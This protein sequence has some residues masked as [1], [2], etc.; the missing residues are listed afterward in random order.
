MYGSWDMMHDRRMDG[1]MDGKS[2]IYR[3]VPHLITSEYYL[4]VFWLIYVH[5]ILRMWKPLRVHV[6]CT[7][8]TVR[9]I[10]RALFQTSLSHVISNSLWVNTFYLMKKRKL[11]IKTFWYLVHVI[12]WN[13]KA[14]KKTDKLKHGW[15]ICSEILE[16]KLMWRKKCKHDS[17]IYFT[18]RRNIM[19]GSQ[20]QGENNAQAL[21]F[22]IRMKSSFFY[23]SPSF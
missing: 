14:S 23:F 1:Q 3:W 2:D 4:K 17:I 20:S 13:M 10:C 11:N 5:V 6:V 16:I 19:K 15:A 21:L 12:S 18:K 22:W 9:T 7:F 8:I